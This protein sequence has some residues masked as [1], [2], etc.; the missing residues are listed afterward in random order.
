[1]KSTFE[2]KGYFK[3]W[4]HQDN[5]TSGLFGKC[6]KHKS[7]RNETF[8]YLL[9]TMQQILVLSKLEPFAGDKLIVPQIMS[10]DK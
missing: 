10:L 7:K 9:I 8:V 5:E 4:L 1:M 3:S 6:Y 2:K